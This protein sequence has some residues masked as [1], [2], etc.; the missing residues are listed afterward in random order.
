MKDYRMKV[1]YNKEVAPDIYELKLNSK[2]KLEEI[3]CGQFLHIKVPDDSLL[4][5]RPFCVYKYDETSITVI[6]AVVG[7]GTKAMVKWKAGDEV[8]A[9]LPLGNGF[10]LEEKHKRI[11]LLGGGVGSAP[12][13][14]V[15]VTYPDKEYFAFLG[16][17]QKNK[18]LFEEDFRQVAQTQIC[19]D[20]GSYGYHGFPTQALEEQLQ[21]IRPDVILTCG[22]HAMMKGVAQFSLKHGIPAYVSAEARMGCGVGACLVCTCGVRQKDGSVVNR[23]VCADGPVFKLEDLV[24]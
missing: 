24:L 13:L 7:K 18:V 22:S 20:D 11:V 17:T 1:V 5:R 15:P 14:A 16:F 12:L 19:T 2:E 21:Q 8:L 6:Y 4:L 23:R 9:T 10:M 3:I